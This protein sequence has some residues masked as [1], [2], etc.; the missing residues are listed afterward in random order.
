MKVM[1]RDFGAVTAQ[2]ERLAVVDS[3]EVRVPG[4]MS[5]RLAALAGAIF[6]ALMVIQANLRSGAPSATDSGQKIFDYVADHA[7]RLQLGAAL[8]GLAMSAVLVWLSGLYRAVRRAEGGGVPAVAVAAL[9][10]G[11]LAAASTVIGALI[12]GTMAV[13]I[14]DLDPAG[15]RVWWTMSLMS[16][17]AMLLG[18]LV[19]IGA[20][21]VVGLRTRLFGRWFAVAGLVLTIVSLVGAFT[22]GYASTGIQVVAGIAVILDGVWILLVSIFMWRDPTLTGP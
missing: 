11:V 13:R 6:F 15:A 3:Q 10:G 21:A 17:G 14:D 12:V 7:G 2:R 19:L 9:A 16:I 5:V 4:V 22:I 8:L 20:T 18:L 1:P